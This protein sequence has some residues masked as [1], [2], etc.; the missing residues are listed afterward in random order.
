MVER[1]NFFDIYGYL[2][3]GALLLGLGWLPVGIV[4]AVWP[5]AEIELALIGGI[6]SYLLG[7]LLHIAH[8]Y[9]FTVKVKDAQ[10][11]DRFPSNLLLDE[12]DDT[13]TP[14]LK[15][16]LADQIEK[17]FGLD[18]REGGD[19]VDGSLERRRFDAFQ[20]CRRW[21]I[22][23]KT[24]SYA[25]QFQALYELRRGVAAACLAA[26]FLYI[27]WALAYLS[28]LLGSGW[29]TTAV[30]VVV[31]IA[32]VLSLP[33]PKKLFWFFGIVLWGAGFVLGKELG[34]QSHQGLLLFCLGLLLGWVSWQFRG[35]YGGFAREFAAT[36]YRDFLVLATT[37]HPTK[38]EKP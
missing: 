2:L 9:F 36:V 24:V 29:D 37:E 14:A 4:A 10:G 25:E 27:G 34:V 13:F 23:E 26:A 28:T 35:T 31:A 15:R 17:R 21:L 33:F 1:F 20:L 18:V 19:D 7:H 32:G 3:P 16:Q 11:K 30:L 38:A 22:Q 6:A 5:P 12:A 8:R